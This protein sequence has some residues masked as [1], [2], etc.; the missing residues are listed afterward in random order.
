MY[1]P[2]DRLL[3]GR[4][5]RPPVLSPDQANTLFPFQLFLLLGIT[6]QSSYYNNTKQELACLSPRGLLVLLLLLSP[7]RLYSMAIG[8]R[9]WKRGSRVR[10]PR[11]VIRK[12]TSLRRHLLLLYSI[13]SSSRD[14]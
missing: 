14:Y 11:A 12:A 1:S 7:D 13:N 5:F 6:T 3:R 8:R 10:A 4:T 2:T 9:G